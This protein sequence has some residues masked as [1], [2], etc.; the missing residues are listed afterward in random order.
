[1]LLKATGIASFIMDGLLIYDP[2]VIVGNGTRITYDETALFNEKF[3]IVP[4]TVS[5][6]VA[7]ESYDSYYTHRWLISVIEEL[8]K[9]YKGSAL[10]KKLSV[11]FMELRAE[12][13]SS[14]ACVTFCETVI[15]NCGRVFYVNMKMDR[16]ENDLIRLVIHDQYLGDMMR[17]R[18]HTTSD[19]VS[20]DAAVIQV[21]FDQAE[22]YAALLDSLQRHDKMKTAV[23]R[24]LP[25]VLKQIRKL[26]KDMEYMAMP[27]AN[28]SA[29]NLK[30]EI[31]NYAT[32]S[33][34]AEIKKIIFN[35]ELI[36]KSRQVGK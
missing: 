26:K 8:E 33:Q 7:A 12:S 9:K 19:Y 27:Y 23:V 28:Y 35:P 4:S 11:P 13:A 17:T 5:S 10:W 18:L 16:N 6:Y 36:M 20:S 32:P 24:S 30:P 34:A 2:N 21:A 29:R 3:F 1:M 25:E 15:N 22:N 31:D 14:L